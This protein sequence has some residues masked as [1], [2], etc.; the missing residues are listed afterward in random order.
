MAFE[1]LLNIA[2][3]ESQLLEMLVSEIQANYFKY[4]NEC[5]F[6]KLEKVSEIQST[7][8]AFQLGN[9][10]P[11]L[12]GGTSKIVRVKTFEDMYALGD[13]FYDSKFMHA[14]LLLKYE[15][16]R[17]ELL[18]HGFFWSDIFEILPD[19]IVDSRPREGSIH[20]EKSLLPSRKFLAQAFG[21]ISSAVT[22]SKRNKSV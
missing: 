21:G 15:R 1:K 17:Y 2:A 16:G 14:C 18:C 12:D 13:F 9:D 20:R 5:Y 10:V 3:Q 7:N 22:T 6:L 11:I 19:K 4:Q 8:K